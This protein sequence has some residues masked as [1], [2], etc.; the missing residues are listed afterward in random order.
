MTPSA[1]TEARYFTPFRDEPRAESAAVGN[2]G[3]VLAAAPPI[4]GPR[5]VLIAGTAG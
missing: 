4:G 5:R 1:G 2:V 3:A